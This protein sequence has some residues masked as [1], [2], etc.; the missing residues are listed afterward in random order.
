MDK[1]P[2]EDASLRLVSLRD[3]SGPPCRR[4]SAADAATRDEN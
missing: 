1:W 4:G 3:L 2:I